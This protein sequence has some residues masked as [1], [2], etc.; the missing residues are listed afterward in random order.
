MRKDRLLKL[1]E[2]LE[3]CSTGYVLRIPNDGRVAFDLGVIVAGKAR[4][5][6]SED[7]VGLEDRGCGSVV[8]AMGFAAL[9]PWFQRRGL[10]LADACEANAL[11]V[12][13]ENLNYQAAAAQFFGVSLHTAAD[14]FS[15]IMNDDDVTPKQLARK[16]RRTVAEYTRG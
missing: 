9:H 1:A 7:L 11:N 10:R 16:I 6:G 4:G 13:G 5:Y 3:R 8:C 14:L 2:E 12:G 15:P